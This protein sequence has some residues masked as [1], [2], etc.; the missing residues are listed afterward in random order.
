[1]VQVLMLKQELRRQRGPWVITVL[2]RLPPSPVRPL[3]SLLTR[4]WSATMYSSRYLGLLRASRLTWEEQM[5]RGRLL[6]RILGHT[7]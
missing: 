6:D 1:M 4:V 3:R 2:S 7:P 5:V